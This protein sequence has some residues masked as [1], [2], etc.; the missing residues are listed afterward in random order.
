MFTVAVL[1]NISTNNKAFDCLVQYLR[2]K[3][4]GRSYSGLYIHGVDVYGHP[5]ALDT[6]VISN[7][8]KLSI[9]RYLSRGSLDIGR[10]SSLDIT[11]TSDPIS[12]VGPDTED[13][14]QRWA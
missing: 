12:R 1:V 14:A 13:R 3:E 7:D 5:W 6:P 8:C 4:I 10:C 2:V 11:L 9:S